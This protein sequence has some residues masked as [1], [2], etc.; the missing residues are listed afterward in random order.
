MYIIWHIELKII[1]YVLE[2]YSIWSKRKI[3]PHD[4]IWQTIYHHDIVRRRSM[5]FSIIFI[6]DFKCFWHFIGNKP[7]MIFDAE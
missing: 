5:A 1:P 3:E 4:Y 2:L 7:I 6:S